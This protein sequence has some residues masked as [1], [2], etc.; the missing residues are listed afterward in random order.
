MPLIDDG[1]G[2][3]AETVRVSLSGAAGGATLGSPAQ[4]ML[5]IT[6]NDGGPV[7]EDGETT[8]CLLDRFFVAV[9][10]KRPSGQEGEGRASKLSDGACAFEFF[11]AGNLGLFV[12]MTSNGCALAAGNPLRNYWVFLAGLTNVE[13]VASDRRHR[14]A[15]PEDLHQPLEHVLQVGAGDDGRARRVPD[16]RPVVGLALSAVGHGTVA[17]GGTV[18][19]AG[20]AAPGEMVARRPTVAPVST[21]ASAPMVAPAYTSHVGADRGRGRRSRRSCGGRRARRSSRRSRST[22]R[23]RAPC[24]RR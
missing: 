24:P 9:H 23:F 22:L 10:W 21:R 8:L 14:R 6:D 5:T 12:K 20:T 15:D 11:E 18:V 17:P 1:E 2:E 4:A 13:V 3:L 19:P 16:L 7:C